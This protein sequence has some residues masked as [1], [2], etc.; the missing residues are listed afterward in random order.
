[1][2]RRLRKRD[3]VALAA[4]VGMAALFGCSGLLGFG[5]YSVQPD[6]AGMQ[7]ETSADGGGDEEASC[8][9]DLT[10]TCYPCEPATTD[11]FLN[12]CTDGTCVSFDKSRLNGFLAPD[13][14]LPALPPPDG[15]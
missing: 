8:N 7:P 11:Q 13:G 4:I 2:A 10:T 6:E 1:M 9:V 15:G 12:K 3:L 14:A 5:D